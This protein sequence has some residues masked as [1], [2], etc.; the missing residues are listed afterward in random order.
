MGKPDDY[1]TLTMAASQEACAP[2]C[3]G[4]C[5]L[6]TSIPASPLSLSF[7]TPIFN[8]AHCH[9]QVKTPFPSFSHMYGG[10]G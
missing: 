3:G 10:Q 5:V 4:G 2:N 9:L 1:V 7:R 6:P 8:W